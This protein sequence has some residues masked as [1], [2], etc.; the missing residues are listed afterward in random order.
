MSKDSYLGD[1]RR[2][3][4]L[5]HA[6]RSPVPSPIQEA[7]DVL[8]LGVPVDHVKTLAH[9]VQQAYEAEHTHT[10]A[11]ANKMTSL[12]TYGYKLKDIFAMIEY[13]QKHLAKG[14]Y[15]EK[16]RDFLVR[17]MKE[18]VGELEKYLQN[19][20]EWLANMKAALPKMEQERGKIAALLKS[21][22]VPK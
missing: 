13:E 3:A 15:G 21:F 20:D 1:F 10:W 4:G 9:E 6:V 7:L 2:L 16:D 12:N 5:S 19:D 8:D 22:K 18:S 17:H 11:F 14:D